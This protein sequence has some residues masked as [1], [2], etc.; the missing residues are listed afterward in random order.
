MT[1]AVTTGLEVRNLARL[2][3]VIVLLCG[4]RV[5]RVDVSFLA[6]GRVAINRKQVSQA[7]VVKVVP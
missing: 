7:I 2:D 4:S 6:G 1:I 3:V 5:A